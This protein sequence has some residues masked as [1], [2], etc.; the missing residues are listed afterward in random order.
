MNS[1]TQ[2]FDTNDINLRIGTLL[3]RQKTIYVKG[4]R[5]QNIKDYQDY[6]FDGIDEGNLGMGMGIENGEYT[7]DEIKMLNEKLDQRKEHHVEWKKKIGANQS[8]LTNSISHELD[9]FE[10]RAT[11]R[12]Q[13]RNSVKE[14]F[15]TLRERAIT[16]SRVENVSYNYK[17]GQYG[18]KSE[19]LDI[20]NIV[21]NE[22]LSKNDIEDDYLKIN[23]QCIEDNKYN[24]DQIMVNSKSKNEEIINNIGKRDKRSLTTD[25]FSMS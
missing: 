8:Q 24:N 14:D 7:K 23:D 25:I 15:E 1:E 5:G 12:Q 17:S 6:I 22:F 9:P 20:H 3:E 18:R 11:L 2:S 13:R 10:R 19:R 4:G 16:K 21:N